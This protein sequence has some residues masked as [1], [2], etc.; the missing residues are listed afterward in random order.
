MI[1]M[2]LIAIICVLVIDLSGFTDEVTQFISKW[3]TNG[4]VIKSFSFK[5]FTC[6][7]CMTWWTCFIYLICVHQLTL[8]NVCFALLMAYSTGIIK[9]VLLLIN[10][11][12]LTLI[13]KLNEKIN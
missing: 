5:P 8:Y 13:N 4:K 9:S 7:L 11:L 1:N 2:I 3:L 12:I 6:S 10:D